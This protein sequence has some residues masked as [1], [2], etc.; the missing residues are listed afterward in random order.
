MLITKAPPAAPLTI[1]PGMGEMVFRIANSVDEEICVATVAGSSNLD[2]KV[3][4]V[5]AT[6]TITPGQAGE[7]EIVLLAAPNDP[8]KGT[9]PAHIYPQWTAIAHTPKEPIGGSTDLD[10]TM[11]MVQGINLMY[12]LASGKMQ[13]TWVS[14]I[15]DHPTDAAD[16]SNALLGLTADV[17]PVMMF[18][19]SVIFTPTTAPVVEP[20]PIATLE[21]LAITGDE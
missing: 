17:D 8:K 13:G 18:A 10:S 1:G 7:L 15:A 3:F 12:Y 14:N 20:Y 6:G 16:M 9:D 5:T 4:N 21:N 11:W 19:V 2:L